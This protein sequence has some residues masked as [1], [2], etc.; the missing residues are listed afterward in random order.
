MRQIQVLAL[1]PNYLFSEEE[2]SVPFCLGGHQFEHNNPRMAAEDQASF[3]AEH[4]DRGGLQGK[5]FFAIF[6]TYFN[7]L[8]SSV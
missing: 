3:R 2:I 1:R 6:S 8:P 4:G 5:N 7:S